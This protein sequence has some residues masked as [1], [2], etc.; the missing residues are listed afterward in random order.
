MHGAARPARSAGF[1]YLLL[2]FGGIFGLEIVPRQTIVHGDAAATAAKILGHEGLYRAGIAVSVLNPVVFL[3]VALALYRLLAEV[4]AS[5]AKL[6]VLFVVV[7]VPLGVG[8]AM[9]QMAALMLVKGEPF[10]A[11]FDAA[12]RNALAMMFLRIDGQG[13]LASELM[14][15]LWL[16]PLAILVYRSGFLPR[17]LG[18]FLGINALAYVALCAIGILWPQHSA[19]ANRYSFFVLLGEPLLTLWLLVMGAKPRQEIAL[20]A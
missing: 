11:V 12:Q 7:Q 16:V 1:V 20:R 14:W 10:L 4:Q 6:M 8:D 9:N 5:L 15:G 13:S 3:L 17:F 2:T 18:V 19:F